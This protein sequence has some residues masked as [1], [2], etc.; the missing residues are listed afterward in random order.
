MLE[1]QDRQQAHRPLRENEDVFVL[2]EDDDM[3]WER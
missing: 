3:E 2:D 1:L